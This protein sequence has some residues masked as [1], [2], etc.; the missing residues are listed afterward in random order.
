MGNEL[1]AEQKR[2]AEILS[3][4]SSG[5]ASPLYWACWNGNV[6]AVR[7]IVAS[8]D[9]I[10]LNQ[11]EPNGSTALHAAVYYNH[12][13]IVRI[14]LHE[15]GVMIHRRNRYN[16]TA[17]EE[18]EDNEIRAL[19]N[20][21]N[22]SQRF[23]DDATKPLVESLEKLIPDSLDDGDIT[24]IDNDW[25]LAA[26]SPNEIRKI[27][28]VAN[29]VKT[30]HRSTA[31]RRT[32]HVWNKMI[33]NDPVA[34]MF[35]ENLAVSKI[36]AMIDDEVTPRHQY[37]KKACLLVS[38]Y[39]NTG[40]ISH[41]LRLYSLETP[42]YS[43]LNEMDHPCLMTPVF[44][45]LDRLQNRAFQGVSYRGLTMTKE[46]LEPYQLLYK[47]QKGVLVFQQF[48]SSSIEEQ[49][50]HGFTHTTSDDKISVMMVFS[51]PEK[52]DTAIQLFQVSNKVP[53]ISDFPQEREVLILPFTLFRQ[54]D[55]QYDRAKKLYR[56]YL[57]NFTSNAGLG[58]LLQSLH[59]DEM[60][61]R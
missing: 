4:P 44:C 51:F 15:K 45:K 13:E 8:T 29:L 10:Q 18:A 46:D 32:L 25:V 50:V 2:E 57:E 27:K 3:N 36:Q 39:R 12:P 11:L 34:Q 61:K 30:L 28:A 49:V 60:S 26:T 23:W 17:Y 31:F 33:K 37:Y 43:A 16:L 1:S 55:I 58:S 38:Q 6:E 20:R 52:C 53:S 59:H 21:P 35:D 19:F 54:T 9:Y 7:R 47:Q 56:I 22:A 41:L 40:D 14:L 48:C 5:E 24:G 42:F